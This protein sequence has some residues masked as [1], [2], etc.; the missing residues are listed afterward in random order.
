MTHTIHPAL[1]PTTLIDLL[2]AGVREVTGVESISDIQ[3]IQA[4]IDA[5]G[6]RLAWRI[7]RHGS[8]AELVEVE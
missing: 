1:L 4:C 6:L 8:T 3:R 7:P 2:E 5:A